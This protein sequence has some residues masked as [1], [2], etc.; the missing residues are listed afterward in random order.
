M[1]TTQYTYATV[2]PH[3]LCRPASA[4]EPLIDPEA[5]S[6]M[7]ERSKNWPECRWAAAQ[8]VVLGSPSAGHLKFIAVGPGRGVPCIE[9]PTLTHWSYYFVGW[10]NLATGDIQEEVP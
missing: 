2:K 3:P 10:V 5:L 6:A 1:S 8:C 9:H 4:A 7:R